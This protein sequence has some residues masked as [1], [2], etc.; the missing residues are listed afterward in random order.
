MTVNEYNYAQLRNV[1]RANMETAK[2][3]RAMEALES[4]KL[5]ESRRHAMVSEQIDRAKVDESI[6]HDSMMEGIQSRAN[7]ISDFFNRGRLTQGQEQ[8]RQ[9]DITTSTQADRNRIESSLLYDN[10]NLNKRKT[11]SE[12]YRNY[13]GANAQT[14]QAESA[15]LNARVNKFNSEV[16]AVTSTVNMIT[17]GLGSIIGRST[18]GSSSKADPTLGDKLRKRALKG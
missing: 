15:A 4:G 8:L 16:N 2:H 12:I 5:E 9:S 3:N 11:D 13:A 14:S 17:K 1:E 10:F 7:D 18:I 6:R